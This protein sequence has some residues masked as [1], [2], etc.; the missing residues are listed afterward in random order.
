M[1]SALDFYQTSLRDP[2]FYQLYNKIFD[3]MVQYKEFLKPYTQDDLDFDGVKIN[4]V[5]VDKLVTYFDLYDFDALNMVIKDNNKEFTQD[6]K[7]RQPRLNHK[8]FTVTIN[9]K[10]DVTTD[11]AFKVWIGPKYD[12]NGYPLTIEKN[13]QNF[14]ELDMFMHKLVPGLNKIERSSD[15][16][17]WFKEDSLPISEIQHLLDEG[18]LPVDMSEDYDSIPER[19]MLPKGT[20]GGM[21]YQIFVYVYKHSPVSKDVTDKYEFLS[22]MMDGKSFGYPLDR[23]ARANCFNEDNMFFEDVLVYHEGEEHTYK[24]ANPAYKAKEL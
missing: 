21:P 8:D 12:S 6:F 2:A 1:P 14:F 4:D 18:K 3:Y 7:I 22:S 5:K 19:L 16:F 20:K 17:F 23:P 24:Y 10:S 15:D 9:V 11:A 13:W